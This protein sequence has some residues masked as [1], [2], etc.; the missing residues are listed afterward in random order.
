VEQRIAKQVRLTDYMARD[1]RHGSAMPK[2]PAD[3]GWL[4]P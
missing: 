1:T 4:S 2:P 3:T